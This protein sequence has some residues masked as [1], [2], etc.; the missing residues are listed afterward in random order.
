M[1]S[2][3]EEGVASKETLWEERKER[4][5]DE[6]CYEKLN[7]IGKKDEIYIHIYIID[8]SGTNIIT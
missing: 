2:W 3:Q 1:T 8:G 4:K 7:A 5:N 6:I